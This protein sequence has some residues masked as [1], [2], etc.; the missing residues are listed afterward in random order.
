MAPKDPQAIRA[1]ILADPNTA[2][3]AETLEV[4]LEEYVEQVLEFAMNPGAEPELLLISDE[5]LKA[6]GAPP[7]PD[8]KE[9]NDYI[10]EG[11]EISA[12]TQGSGYQK[13]AKPKVALPEAPPAKA[14]PDEVRDDLKDDVKSRRG[15]GGKV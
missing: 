2:R 4:P 14:S 15:G 1:A 6:M 7:P 13:A 10:Q 11:L 5:N 8:M 12:V 9:M 3:I